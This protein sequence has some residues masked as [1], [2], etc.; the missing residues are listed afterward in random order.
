MCTQVSAKLP[1]LSL[2]GSIT[3]TLYGEDTEA[4]DQAAALRNALPVIAPLQLSDADTTL[5]LHKFTLTNPLAAEL[6]AVTAA[7][8]RQL[9]FTELTWPTDTDITTPLP[10]TIT[11]L[12]LAEPLTDARLA[13]LLQVGAACTIQQLRVP[14]LKLTAAVAEGTR[15]PFEGV[16]L[17]QSVVT[18]VTTFLPQVELLGGSVDWDLYYLSLSSTLD[19]VGHAAHTHIHTHTHTHTHTHSHVCDCTVG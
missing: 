10:P 14:E 5:E 15:L 16:H 18:H 13:Q 9:S 17:K 11:T 2:S 7:G 1:R 12:A 8:W 3:V 19:Q 4:E 6:A